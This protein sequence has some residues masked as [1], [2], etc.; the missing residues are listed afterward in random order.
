MSKILTIN[1]QDYTFEFAGEAIFC[2]EC[3]TELTGFL[4]NVSQ[5][6]NE[7]DIRKLLGGF[8]RI[9]KLSLTLF[10]TGLI[11]HHGTGRRGDKRVPDMETAK[12]LLLD[13]INQHKDDEYGS[14]VGVINM[15]IQQMEEEGYLKAIGINKVF[16]GQEQEEAD[17]R[18]K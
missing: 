10:Y 17:A 18:S 12:E 15:C 4:A 7:R 3:V 9:P 2:A 1:E 11:E 14:M 13:Y 8:S 16:G 5:A 6:E